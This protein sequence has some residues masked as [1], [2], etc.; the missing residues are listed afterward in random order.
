MTKLFGFADVVSGLLFVGSFY[1]VDIPRGMMMAFG[2]YLILKGLIFI[3]NFFSLIDVGAG[4]LLISGWIFAVHPF[5]LIGIAAFLCV[6][7][8]VSLFTFG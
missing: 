7:G 8:L 6:K 3:M 4:I 1:N 5:I 2:I